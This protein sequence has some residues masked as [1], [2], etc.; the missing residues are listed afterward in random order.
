MA[1]AV[2]TIHPCTVTGYQLLSQPAPWVCMHVH[3]QGRLCAYICIDVC[4]ILY[5]C[6]YICI[7][8]C[9]YG[10][11]LCNMNTLTLW[12]GYGVCVCINHVICF[13]KCPFSRW[14]VLYNVLYVF[15]ILF[16]V[17]VLWTINYLYSLYVLTGK[18]VWVYRF[19]FPLLLRG[20]TRHRSISTLADCVGCDGETDNS[21]ASYSFSRGKYP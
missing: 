11:C 8:F 16:Y 12:W 9:V 10:C 14:S 15:G 4:Y 3:M 19:L 13:V 17:Y 1:S 6:I 5:A 20:A 7:V 21:Q 2:V 18:Y